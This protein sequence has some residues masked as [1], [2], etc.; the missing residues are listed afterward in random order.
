MVENALDTDEQV[1][2][3]VQ[4]ADLMK[5]LLAKRDELVGT[6]REIDGEILQIQTEMAQRLEGARDKRAPIERALTHLEAL[7][8]IEGWTESDSKNVK[9]STIISSDGKRA[10]DAAHSLLTTMGSPLHYRD[11]AGQ[12]VESGIYIGGKDPA[13]TLLS[14]ISRD[15]RFQRAA[16]RGVYGLAIWP[17]PKRTNGKR[18]SKTKRSRN[19]RS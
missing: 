13:A 18:K 8:R 5:A 2:S 9:Q 14:K 1:S 4:S 10:A 3:P 17:M 12:I 15:N 11:L 16:E 6:L 7:L 19:S